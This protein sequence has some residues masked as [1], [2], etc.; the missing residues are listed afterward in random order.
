V[1]GILGQLKGKAIVIDGETIPAAVRQMKKAAVVVQSTQNLNK[2]EELAK[3]LNQII[4]DLKFFNTVCGPT[5]A[6]QAEIRSLPL[7]NDVIIIIGSKKSANTRRLLEI[8][9]SL[10]PRSHLVENKFDMRQEWFAGARTVGVTA[11]AST[12]DATTQDII[13]FLENLT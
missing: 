3:K 12:P 6:K 11:G 5:R 9:Q 7:E 13:A 1:H 4:P 2:V 10:N 8:A